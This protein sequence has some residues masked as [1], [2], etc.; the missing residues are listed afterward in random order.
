MTFGNC[1]VIRINVG[2][3]GQKDDTSTNG[4]PLNI[5]FELV[6]FLVFFEFVH[7]EVKTLTA[8]GISKSQGKS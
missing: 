1:V 7:P 3:E 2:Y 6:K 8:L 5:I 4:K